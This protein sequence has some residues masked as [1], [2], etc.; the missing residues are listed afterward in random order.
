M[1]RYGQPTLVHKLYAR[2]LSKYHSTPTDT[3]LQNIENIEAEVHCLHDY[4]ECNGTPGDGTTFR[5][6]CQLTEDQTGYFRI[7]SARLLPC[8]GF[9]FH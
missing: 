7:H 3:R 1:H 5:T 9:R 6:N 2:S 8:E 4:F